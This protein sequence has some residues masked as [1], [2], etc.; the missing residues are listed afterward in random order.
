MDKT[1]TAFIIVAF[2]LVV[3]LL[4]LQS[5]VESIPPTDAI[6]MINT[7]SGNVTASR[8][9]SSVEFV[10]GSGITIT[11]DYLSNEITFT[12]TGGGGINNTISSIGTQQSIV[13]GQILNDHQLK[14]IACGGDL[15][16]SNNSTDVTI[17][18]T[19]SSSSPSGTLIL[20]SANETDQ[21]VT[22]LN[23]DTVVRTYS[24][25]NNTYSRII[26]ESEVEVSFGVLSIS[27]DILIKIKNGGSTE[28]TFTTHSLAQV[29][30]SAVPI[31]ASF[32]Q[33]GS[34]TITITQSGITTDV[35]TNVL[36]HSI[37]IYGVI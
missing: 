17:S 37:R 31:K 15:Q 21:T 33:T 6:Y 26:V 36:V 10:E 9:N 11:P 5:P 13:S 4:V 30:T 23:S 12:A 19:F 34:A 29:G 20:L 1:A 16:C 8:Y 32:V 24:L 25:A 35:N 28:E 27:Q 2:L 18:Y 22:I 3:S 7:T 14:G